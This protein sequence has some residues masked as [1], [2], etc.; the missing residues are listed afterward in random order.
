MKNFI[1]FLLLSFGVFLSAQ[2]GNTINDAI[3]VDGTILQVDVV[4][5]NASTE[6]NLSPV[7]GSSPDLFYKNTVSNGDNKVTIGMASVGVLF[8][9]EFD[10]QILVAPGGNISNIEEIECSTFVVPVLASANFEQVIDN[11]TEGDVYYL[12]IHNPTGLGGLL[13]N[14]ISSTVIT[15]K[16]EFDES[17]SVDKLDENSIEYIVDSEVIKILNSDYVE[18]YSIYS[19]EGKKVFAEKQAQHSNTINISSLNSGVYICNIQID[20]KNQSFKFIKP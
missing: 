4:N 9:A 1:L 20:A 12:R 17:L 6:S 18:N 10:Y 8:L 14:L 13:S 7:C 2:N 15:M 16:S 11:V 5:L 3:S 19:I